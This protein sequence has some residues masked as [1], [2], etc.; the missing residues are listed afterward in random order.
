VDNGMDTYLLVGRKDEP[1]IN[2][3][4]AVKPTFWL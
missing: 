2:G 1:P 4:N 3:P